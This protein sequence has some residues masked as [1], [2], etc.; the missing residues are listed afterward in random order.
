[1]ATRRL[2]P[3][4]VTSVVILVPI[5]TAVAQNKQP[6]KHAVASDSPSDNPPLAPFPTAGILPKEEIGALRFLK[7]NPRCDGRGVVVAIFDSGV[8]L[9]VAGLERTTD[10]KPKIIDV[11]DGTGS[12]D[13][14][15]STTRE[16]K[17]NQIEGLSG[18]PLKLNPAWVKPG[19]KF[20][21]GLKRGYDLFTDELIARLKRERRTAF[22]KAQREV[23]TGLRRQLADWDGQHPKPSAEQKLKRDDLEA[24]LRV[25][26]AADGQYDDP[27]PVYDCVVFHDGKA[28]QAVV[29]T[30]EDGDLAEEKRLTNFRDCLHHF[31]RLTK[32]KQQIIGICDSTEI[33]FR[34]LSGLLQNR[35]SSLRN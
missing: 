19:R 8:D 7:Q 23:E 29:D 2:C 27:G 31:G 10:G 17:G 15:T 26:R 33:L 25:L 21:V 4:L 9:G 22:E 13:V 11:I 14:D 6:A 24:R 3:V 30:D 34:S 5:L 18:R 32:R 16:P 1:M 28:W 12:G 20:H 35:L